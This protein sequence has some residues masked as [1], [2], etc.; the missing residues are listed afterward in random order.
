MLTI[1]FETRSVA[2]LKD[3]GAYKYA[4]HPSTEIVCVAWT[5]P[6]DPEPRLW[7]PEHI[8]GTNPVDDVGELLDAVRNGESIEAHNA[9]F[10]RRIWRFVGPRLRWPEVKLDQWHCSMAKAAA[11]GLPLYLGK[12]AEALGCDQRKDVNG[13]RLIN[14]LCIGKERDSGG[15][16]F[17]DAPYIFNQDPDKLAQLFDYCKQDVRTECEISSHLENLS[18]KERQVWLLDQ[19]M[20]DRGWYVDADLCRGVIAATELEKIAKTGELREVTRGRVESPAQV[21]QLAAFLRS[22]GVDVQNVD[23]ETLEERLRYDM[24]PAAKRA[25]EIRL[26]VSKASA[27]KFHALE[28]YRGSDGRAR[29]LLQYCAAFTGR[30]GGRGPQIQNFPR[31]DEK[32]YPIDFVADL[33]QDADWLPMWYRPFDAAKSVARGALTAAPGKRL[34][35]WDFGQIEARVLAWLAGEESLMQIF[36]EYDAGNGP[37][38]YVATARDI[39]GDPTITKATHP[40][41]RQVGK[42]AVL[43]LGYQMGR[44]R[45]LG[46]LERYGVANATAEFAARVVET[47]RS[48]FSKITIFWDRLDRASRHTFETGASS[49]VGLIRFERRERFLVCQLPSGRR[50]YYFD[51]RI[52]ENRFGKPAISYRQMKM[53]RFMRVD[54]YGGKIAENITQAVARDCLVEGML[55]LDAAEFPLIATI[56]DEAIAEVDQEDM[57]R[58]LIRGKQLLEQSADWNTGLP[59]VADGFETT[60]YK[61]D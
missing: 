54:M 35:V 25:I 48:R 31:G 42:A 19:E 51:P 30:W 3:V 56:H 1:D 11:M 8:R 34:L 43:G 5:W 18:E 15:K 14:L 58:T 4:A 2:N 17:D 59:L 7:S 23:A 53:G 44:E 10:E 46:E 32:Q 28:N 45:F 52:R 60:R 20:N 47:Y 61:K 50:I 49:A 27:K 24:S 36:A 21:G 37:D 57:S 22:E 40:E 16:L 12:L 33:F 29:D 13:T 26:E 6:G 9:G 41:Q 55:R 39:Y 38:P